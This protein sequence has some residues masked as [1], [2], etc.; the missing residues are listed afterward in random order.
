MEFARVHLLE[1]VGGRVVDVEVALRVGQD[2]SR[3]GAEQIKRGDIGATATG[4][5]QG[6]AV[7]FEKF[8]PTRG[9]RDGV[10]LRTGELEAARLKA[11]VV[12]FEGE[13]MFFAGLAREVGV[14]G[15]AAEAVFFVGEED[16]AE[17]VARFDSEGFEEAENFHG[18][19]DAGAVV[20]RAGR[21]VPRIKVAA[22]DHDLIGK[23]GA[24][25]L[26]DDV[27]GKGVG[28][29]GGMG[30]EFDA[31]CGIDREGG[32]QAVGGDGGEGA[33]GDVRAF[34]QKRGGAGVRDVVERVR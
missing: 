9:A 34:G 19:D 1:V 10:E 33:R 20:V 13:D 3:R 14:G 24:A 7:G 8:G 30:R 31:D 5:E 16:G 18:L 29:T 2:F 12:G 32:A 11:A 26:A 23:F 22:D 28:V 4:D 27:V 21:D 15:G 17:G 6:Q 25:D